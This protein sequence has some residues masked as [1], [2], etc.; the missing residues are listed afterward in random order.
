MAD[1]KAIV[2]R[3][4]KLLALGGGNP[5]AEEATSAVLMAQRLIAKYDIADNE[6]SDGETADIIEV[7]TEPLVT[8]RT[9]R[10]MLAVT[11]AAAFRCKVWEQGNRVRPNPYG[12]SYMRPSMVFYGYPQDA[13]AAQLAFAYLYR[14]GNRLANAQVRKMRKADRPVHGAYNSYITGFLA[15]LRSELERQS[16]EL[17]LSMPLAVTERYEAEVAGRLESVKRAQLSC[18]HRRKWLIEQ[19]LLDGRN[20]VRSRRLEDAD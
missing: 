7:P 14:T 8:A 12:R 9:W 19:G 5:C 3:I 20:A 16:R 1:R 17:M 15:G 4:R 2:M 13:H 11:V 18:D 6:L 10:H